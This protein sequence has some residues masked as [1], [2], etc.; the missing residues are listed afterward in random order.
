MRLA[1]HGGAGRPGLTA[2]GLYRQRREVEDALKA[3]SV[4]AGFDAEY[5]HADALRGLA[6]RLG[7]GAD[8][9][10]DMARYELA[11]EEGCLFFHEPV[12]AAIRDLHA[13]GAR[14]VLISDNY[15][16]QDQIRQMLRHGDVLPHVEAIFLSSAP[17][18]RKDT[19]RLFD[20]VLRE[21]RISPA[22]LLHVGDNRHSDHDVPRGKGIGAI[23]LDLPA[24][25][26]R[27]SA[28]EELLPVSPPPDPAPELL[29]RAFDIT[30]RSRHAAA[31]KAALDVATALAPAL[32][33]YTEA[34]L[35]RAIELDV[36]R[37]VFLAREGHLLRTLFDRVRAGAPAS[38]YLH[39]SRVSTYALGMPALNRESL[40]RMFTSFCAHDVCRVSA[41][42]VLTFLGID[43]PEP[44]AALAQYDLAPD[45]HVDLREAPNR[46]RLARPLLDP[47][48]RA[49]YAAARDE[50]RRTFADYLRQVGALDGDRVLFADIGWAGSMQTFIADFMREIGHT[51]TV[52]GFYF[53]YDQ[54][55]DDLKGTRRKRPDIVKDAL[56]CRRTRDDEETTPIVSRI[57]LELITTAPHGTTVAYRR[58][59]ERVMP[60]CAWLDGE[61]PQFRKRVA[62]IQAPLVDMV[63]LTWR[64]ARSL[65]EILP[66]ADWKQGA[67][68]R[69][70]R[71]L[72]RPGRRIARYFSRAVLYD[73]C[74]GIERRVSFRCGMW[75]DE[76]VHALGLTYLPWRLRHVFLRGWLPH[77]RDGGPRA[78]L[79][80]WQ[81]GFRSAARQA[82]HRLRRGVFP[83]GTDFAIT[84]QYRFVRPPAPPTTPSA[85][86][87]LYFLHDGTTADAPRAARHLALA[88]DS[89]DL[90]YPLASGAFGVVRVREGCRLT[91]ET[92]SPGDAGALVTTAHTLVLT[93]CATRFDADYLA[94]LGAAFDRQPDADLV[95]ADNDTRLAGCYTRPRFKPDWSPEYYL[96]FDYIG[97]VVAVRREAISGDALEFLRTVARQG[98]YAT[99]LARLA[100]W[101]RVVHLATVLHHGRYAAGRAPAEILLP[102]ARHVYGNASLQRSPGG[103]QRPVAELGGTPPVSIIIPFRNKRA[104]LQRCLD[105]IF[106]LSTYPHYEIL[107]VDNQ[108]DEPGLQADLEA[109]RRDPRVRV[110]RYDEPFN[111]AA[112]N[113]FAA[114]QARH[115]FLLLLNN[116]IEVLTPVWLEELLRQAQRREVGA[117]GAKLLYPDRT[118]QHAGVVFDFES[119]YPATH[120]FH[121]LAADSTGYE[122]RLRTVQRYTA[123]TAACLM[124]RREVFEEVGG[125]DAARYRVAYNDLDLCCRIG[126]RGYG[127]LWTPYATLLH[128][129]NVS[130]GNPL[131]SAQ[132]RCERDRF[133]A[134]WRP[135]FAHGDPWYTPHLHLGGSVRSCRPTGAPP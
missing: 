114:A 70:S 128:H 103:R 44:R 25:A 105:S 4:S 22:Q 49:A 88:N 64:L 45:R 133:L 124:L 31:P 95:Y 125:F 27:R 11:L 12:V 77:V 104:Y 71:L 99:L 40:E 52:H 8:A 43:Q 20:H 100:D 73:N 29:M 92:L 86:S 91:A 72:T 65:A 116:D 6:S 21:L 56:V 15:L 110:L 2:A 46:D 7:L 126:A 17:R 32:G 62:P 35:A 36:P 117:V 61:E 1:Q 107:L 47:R 80:L 60:V 76:A 87:A 37:V 28:L 68:Q 109:L 127:I 30:V 26:R 111:Y 18:L 48:I 122:E 42:Q 113:N 93:S 90:L 85:R 135:F 123:V 96:E 5:R 115:P 53:G 98:V 34:L 57:V 55:W 112:I 33:V 41:A 82:A 130:R 97:D 10:D 81:Y 84:A 118:I 134:Q 66:A 67:M 74:F 58:D 131:E 38:A 24:D 39:A 121:R 59:G 14:V 9:A 129:E 19:G 54:H 79:C 102:A 78:A 75:W 51:A 3:E 120:I 106:R 16:D 50:V 89:A 119:E 132:D 63:T 69:C 101:R 94:H 13:R 108:S 23:L 83:L